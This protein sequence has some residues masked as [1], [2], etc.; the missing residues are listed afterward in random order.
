[1]KVITKLKIYKSPGP[2]RIHNRVLYELRNEVVP[3]LTK[4]FSKS[5][6]EGCIPNRWK[7]AEVTPI[8]KKGSKSDPN[9]YRPVSLTSTCCKLMETIVRDDIMKHIEK[10]NMLTED[11]HGFRQKRSCCTQLLET[12][13]DWAKADDISSPVDVIYLDYRKAFDSVPHGRILEKLKLF[14]INSSIR[15]WI[16]SFLLID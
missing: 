6:T 11:Q 12:V 7:E 5:L 14:G 13:H 1:M 15:T 10:F 4:T 3:P 2:D 8:Y 16:S 9:N